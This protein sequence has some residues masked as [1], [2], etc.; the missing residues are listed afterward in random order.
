[1]TVTRALVETTCD[2]GADLDDCGDWQ[3]TESVMDYR[4]CITH[5]KITERH[6]LSCPHGIVQKEPCDLIDVILVP[7]CP[8]DH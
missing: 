2:C 5:T 3:L 7:R 8:D 6:Q 1:M 4:W